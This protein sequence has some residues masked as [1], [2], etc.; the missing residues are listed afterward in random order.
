[1]KSAFLALTLLLLCGC[2]S[3]PHF[4]EQVLAF[5]Q[6]GAAR[7]EVQAKVGFA[8]MASVVRPKEGWQAKRDLNHGADASAARFEAEKKAE[9]YRVEVYWIGR[10]TSIP[11]AAGGVWWDYLFYDSSD[12]LLG[13]QRRFLD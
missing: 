12:H 2:A 6:T 9:V 1:M 5:Y 4:D 8:P 13:Y 3:G 11:L 7:D 10:G